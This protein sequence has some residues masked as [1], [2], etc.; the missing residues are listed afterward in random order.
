MDLLVTFEI[1]GN[2]GRPTNVIGN[3]VLAWEA[4]PIN[5]VDYQDIVYELSGVAPIPT[6]GSWL[7]AAPAAWLAMRRRKLIRRYDGR[8]A[9]GAD[10]LPGPR[11]GRRFNSAQ[12]RPLRRLS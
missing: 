6:P 3:Y 4:A 7:G 5:D 10:R 12:R 1:V 9:L 2:A 11:S 8:P